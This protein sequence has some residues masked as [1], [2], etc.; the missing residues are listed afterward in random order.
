MCQWKTAACRRD[1]LK[2]AVVGGL[3]AAGM[4][5]LPAWVS[6]AEPATTKAPSRVALTAGN[7]RADQRLS[8]AQAFCGRGCRAIGDRRVVIKPNNV[9]NDNPLAATNAGCIEGIL[10]FLKSID[11]ASQ[12]VIAESPAGGTAFDAFESYGY[13][14][15]RRNTA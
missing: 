11:K 8:G 1:F 4:L 15:W 5:R 12:A 13:L 2:T 6:A 10:E 3:G 14:R 7:D 9:V